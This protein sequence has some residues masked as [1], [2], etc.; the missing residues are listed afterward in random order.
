MNNLLP[1]AKKSVPYVTDAGTLHIIYFCVEVGLF[2]VYSNIHVENG[3]V[4]QGTPWYV[5][6]T[7][8]DDAIV[9]KFRAYI[10]ESDKGIEV[11]TYLLAYFLDI[12][13]KPREIIFIPR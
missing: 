2:W 11:I 7:T 10:F 4:E 13:D 5:W 3:G 9:Q 1:G 8:L 6:V 12:K